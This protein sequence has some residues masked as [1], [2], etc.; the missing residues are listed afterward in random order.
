M[1]PR[2]QKQKFGVKF[3]E[4][5]LYYFSKINHSGFTKQTCSENVLIGRKE[6]RSVPNGQNTILE[7]LAKYEIPNKETRVV[8][9]FCFRICK[10]GEGANSFY[11]IFFV[12]IMNRTQSSVMFFSS[13]SQFQSLPH[14]LQ[15]SRLKNLTSQ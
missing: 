11:S 9:Q 2:S 10:Q 8:F 1:Y 7:N 14:C 15:F 4:S 13:M 3:L 12:C 5:G 6:M